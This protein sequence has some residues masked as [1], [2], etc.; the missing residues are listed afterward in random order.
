MRS[1][2][3]SNS[4]SA[5][6]RS[7]PVVAVTKPENPTCP[8]RKR[9]PAAAAW[10]ALAQVQSP[11][12]WPAAEQRPIVFLLDASSPLERRLL[13]DWVE[14]SRPATVPA[15]AWEAIPIPPSRRGRRRL[16]PRLEARLATG[17]DPLLAPLRVAW[18]PPNVNGTREAR[19]SDLWTFGDPRDP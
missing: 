15:G 16:D 10:D 3:R 12:A 19:L 13:E 1:P 9:A 17:D 6:P 5:R 7:I 4:T 8:S 11:P 14:R 18:D 2:M